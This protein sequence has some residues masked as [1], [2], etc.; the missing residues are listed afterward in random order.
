LAP[1][2]RL[3]SSERTVVVATHHLP[4]GVRCPELR[5]N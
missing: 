2:S 4:K 5:I 1:D 3:M